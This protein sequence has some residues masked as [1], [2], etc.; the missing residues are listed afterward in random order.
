MTGRRA[1]HCLDFGGL[2][3]RVTLREDTD[4]LGKRFGKYQTPG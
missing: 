4:Q 2:F 1:V 3:V